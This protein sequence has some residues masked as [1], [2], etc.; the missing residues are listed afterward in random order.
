MKTFEYVTHNI[1]KHKVQE[2]IRV[3]LVT[4][5]TQVVL[6]ITNLLYLVSNF[7]FEGSIPHRRNYHASQF[8][9]FAKLILFIAIKFV[10]MSCD[11]DFVIST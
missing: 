4:I 5:R 8:E 11:I 10:G 3:I 1:W 6:F 7:L 2:F 9:K